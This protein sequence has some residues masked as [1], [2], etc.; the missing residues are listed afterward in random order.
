MIASA[1]FAPPIFPLQHEC[2]CEILISHQT[3][4]LYPTPINLGENP[5]DYQGS[6]S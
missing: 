4:Q 2:V 1:T 6:Q 5:F 3:V